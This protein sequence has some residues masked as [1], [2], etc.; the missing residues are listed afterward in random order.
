MA[1]YVDGAHVFR[2]NNT[3]Q[4]FWNGEH[5][6]G[7][8]VVHSGIY[9]CAGCNKEVTCNSGDQFPPQNHHQ[10]TILTASGPVRWHLLVMTN[11]EGK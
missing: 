10:H 4:A 2:I 6:P 3:D 9:R 5:P 8:H 1:W 7:S 11:T